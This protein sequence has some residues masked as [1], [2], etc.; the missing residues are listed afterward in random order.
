MFFDRRDRR[1]AQWP[2][3]L[4]AG[5]C[6]AALATQIACHTYRPMQEV[7]PASGREVAVE[8][9]DRGRV[10]VGGQLG[11]SVLQVHGRIIASTDSAVTLSVAR[12]VLLQGS[13]AVW[14]GETVT[15]PREGVRGFR[16]REYSRSRTVMLSV[17]IAVGLVILGGIINLAA[18]GNGKPDDGGGCTNNCGQQ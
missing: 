18:G 6:A 9:N 15:I 2:R 1:G 10:L 12:T 11:E 16:V 3:R 5:L 7:V 14:T 8:L 13:T 4:T 17:G